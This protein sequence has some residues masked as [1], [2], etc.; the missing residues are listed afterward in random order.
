MAPQDRDALADADP[1]VP[2]SAIAEDAME[3]ERPEEPEEISPE[4]PEADA[5]EQHTGIGQRGEQRWEPAP[6]DDVDPADLDEQRR[7]VELDEDDY[8]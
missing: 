1:E 4:A 7:T 3:E 6:P 2:E 5:V 8:R